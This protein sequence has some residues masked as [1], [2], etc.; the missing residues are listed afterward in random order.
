MHASSNLSLRT[1]ER[2]RVAWHIVGRLYR[3]SE[4]VIWVVRR[5]S[6]HLTSWQPED[7]LISGHAVCS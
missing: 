7:Q 2:A 3:L 6:R 5:D 1:R 4:V